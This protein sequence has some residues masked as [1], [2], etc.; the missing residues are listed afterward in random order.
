MKV[1]CINAKPVNCDID[2]I[3]GEVYTVIDIEM[4]QNKDYYVLAEIAKPNSFIKDRFIP[5]S[6]IDETEIVKQRETELI[7]Q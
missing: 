4:F 2:L 3:E 6:D 1:L 7:N 5:L